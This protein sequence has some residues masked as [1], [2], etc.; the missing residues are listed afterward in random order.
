MQ[1]RLVVHKDFRFL[2]RGIQGVAH[3]GVL[4]CGIFG[5]RNFGSGKFLHVGGTLHQG[6]NVEAGAG[7]GEQAHGGEHGEASAHVVGD[8]EALVTLLVGSGAGGAFLGIGNGHNHLAGHLHAALFLALL[9]QQ[10][11]GEGGFS[12][13]TALGDVDDAELAV[14]Q[15]GGQ[16]VQVV[17]ADVVAGK[18]DNGVLPVVDEPFKAVAQ[19]LDH[20]PGTE[21]ATAD[22]CHHDGVAVFAHHLCRLLEVGEVFGGYAGGQVEPSQKIV[23]RAGAF[24][25]CLL[26]SLHTRFECLNGTGRQE[27]YSLVCFQTDILIHRFC[28]L[29][30]FDGA[31]L[32]QG[33]CR[34]KRKTVQSERKGYKKRKSF[35]LPF[36]N[37]SRLYAKAVGFSF[38][39]PSRS[40]HYT[41]Y[42]IHTFVERLLS[43]S[44]RPGRPRPPHRQ[45]CTFR[46]VGSHPDRYVHSRD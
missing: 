46:H 15:V 9:A 19:S 29:I 39:M 31:K 36:P 10:S 42:I 44:S 30:S 3:G 17:F 21:V 11:E 34:T 27:L 32:V 25:Q 18:E 5:K 1:L 8:D 28:D 37:C 6:L 16:F 14:L 40:L 13:G 45:S 12:S 33:E 41:F 2:T 7:D 22:A 35:Y 38:F 43:S 4:L 24:F 20:C 23:A 26:G